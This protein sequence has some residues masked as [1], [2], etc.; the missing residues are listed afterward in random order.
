MLKWRRRH[1]LVLF[2]PVLLLVSDDLPT[3][4]A[5]SD[6]PQLLI[7]NAALI[8]TMDP[9]LGAG[10]LGLLEDSDVLLAGDAIAAIGPG[11]KSRGDSIDATGKIV[12]PGFVDVHNH[13]WQ[14]FIRGCGTDLDLLSW[15]DECASAFKQ[16]TYSEADIAAG[17]RLSTLDLITTGVTTVVDWS[18]GWSPAFVEGNL[19]A[20]RESGLRFVFAYVGSTRRND[21]EHIRRIKRQVIDPNPRASFQVGSHPSTDKKWF[22]ELTA[23]SKLARELDVALHVHL[24]EHVKQRAEEPMRALT[25]ADALKANLLA[26]HAIHLTT[27]EIATLA[28]HNVRVAHNPL[29]NMRLAS[30]IIRLPELHAAGIKVGLGLDGGTND[31][32][33]M[34]NTMRT[35]VGLQRATSRR[36]DIFPT[37]SDVLRMATLGGAEVL[38]LDAEIGSL[39]PG[40]K[41]DVIILDPSTVNFAPRVEWLS[42]IVFNGQPGNVEWVFVDGQP[43]KARGQLVN[44][45]PAA[46]VR[47]AEEAARRV[48]Q[49]RHERERAP[50]GQ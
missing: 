20:L 6:P 44:V 24:L 42:Q 45:D 11:L 2:A 30:G 48:R 29:S 14:S 9:S 16:L 23:M 46:I 33:D 39:T 13:L 25:L 27:Q 35:A 36:A 50:L 15:L 12:M 32:S 3:R 4:S 43:L 31:T 7:H 34:F 19:R 28:K 37:V 38:D 40:K 5:L 26:A 10:P 21:I 1:L 18:A 47:E 41:A 17:V 49:E 8:L 22:V